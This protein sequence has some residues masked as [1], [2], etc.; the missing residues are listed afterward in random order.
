MRE[1]NFYTPFARLFLTAA[2][3]ALCFGAARAQQTTSANDANAA[4]QTSQTSERTARSKYLISARAGGINYAHGSVLRQEKGAEG[5][6][7]VT[8]R[9]D[10]DAGDALET[11]SDA[12]AEI[13][14]APGTYLRLNSD[15]RTEMTNTDLDDLRVAVKT[16]SVI[17][18]V[19]GTNGAGAGTRIETP[20]TSVLLNRDG[21][22]RLNV[23]GG[24]TEVIALKGEAEVGVGATATIV[25]KNKR[26]IVNGAAQ[27]EIA[28]VD[29]H[30]LDAFDE[31]SKERAHTLADINT[32][33]ASSYARTSNPSFVTALDLY[34]ARFN[35]I[36]S[37][38]LPSPFGLW[39]YSPFYGCRTFLP[40]YYGWSSPYGY[41]YYFNFGYP[42]FYQRN[43]HGFIRPPRP[44]IN[45]ASSAGI[46]NRT[47][48]R[49]WNGEAPSAKSNAMRTS[50]MHTMPSHTMP[51]HVERPTRAH[52]FSPAPTR[53]YSP[54]P[55]PTREM[56]PAAPAR[57][58]SPSVESG[59]KVQ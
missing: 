26:L 45:V 7:R 3:A 10:L 49:T 8:T 38:F 4:A 24:V 34:W 53:E 40:F 29:K 33:L 37:S 17:V 22:Y 41:S 27:T 46:T 14:L 1:K 6:Q 39:V 31:W 16:G 51:S 11:G 15:T 48:S 59:R 9:D 30:S 25:K 20:Q 57:T 42:L 56:S 19:T 54:A 35:D 43:P 5:W 58:M 44:P 47:L 55:M 12:R 32:Q 18:E 2:T 28:S 13:A 50:P 52:E 23:T 36:S 21:L